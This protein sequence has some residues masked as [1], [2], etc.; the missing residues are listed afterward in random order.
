MRPH[1]RAWTGLT[2]RMKGAEGGAAMGVV[3]AGGLLLVLLLSGFTVEASSF[4]LV[5]S[6]LFSP[7][8]C[9]AGGAW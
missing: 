9:R 3:R 6:R 4:S 1:A 7:A 5:P 2:K 8:T